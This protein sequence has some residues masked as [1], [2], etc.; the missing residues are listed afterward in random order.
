[1]I[2]D[3]G[4]GGTGIVAGTLLSCR[5]NAGILRDSAGLTAARSVF[6]AT[7]CIAAIVDGGEVSV[8]WW[9]G[10]VKLGTS[11]RS[12]GIDL[13]SSGELHLQPSPRHLTLHNPHSSNGVHISAAEGKSEPTRREID[14]LTGSKQVA[15]PNVSPPPG[16]L[17]TTSRARRPARYPLQRPQNRTRHY[18][19][20]YREGCKLT[21]LLPGHRRRSGCR[22]DAKRRRLLRETP[23]RLSARTTAE[24]PS[25]KIPGEIY[26]QETECDAYVTA[27]IPEKRAG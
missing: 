27:L 16:A 7:L 17:P 15:S 21:M 26:G 14:T 20:S 22:P 18:A 4:T 25:A 6:A 11:W 9:M 2:P 13:L 19:I 3:R 8:V 23:A 1:M 24:G 12:Q 5:V 10:E